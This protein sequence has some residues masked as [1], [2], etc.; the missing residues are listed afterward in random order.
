MRY[1]HLF[2]DLDHT[3]WDLRTNTRHTLLELHGELELAGR[4]IDD[5][6]GFVDCYEEINAGLWGHYEAGRIPKE[7]LRV[8]R[9]RETLLR[10]G[11]KD[12]RLARRLA[13]AYLDRC[14]RRTALSPGVAAMLA[15]VTGRAG[16]HIITNGFREVQ[17]V[18]LRS[19]GIAHHFQV[20]L[21]SEEAGAPKPDGRIYAEALRRAGASPQESVMI[22]DDARNDVEGALD[23]GMAAVHYRI[24][25]GGTTKRATH[26]ID[27][28]DQLLPLLDG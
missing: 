6:E 3:L 16:L 2:F 27:H 26:V 21:T 7:V 18:K 10:H 15:A 8:L 24:P 14:P 17:G 23:A 5:A 19:A 11:V 9:F 12:D 25:G 4:G 22:G 20:V 13:E 1:R 28:F